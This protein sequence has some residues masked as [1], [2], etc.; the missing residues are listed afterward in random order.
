MIHQRTHIRN[1]AFAA[2]RLA[3]AADITMKRAAPYD[4]GADLMPCV[5]VTGGDGSAGV[6]S[7]SLDRVMV[8]EISIAARGKPDAIEDLLDDLQA[9]VEVAL[10]A[11][12]S[13]SGT[14]QTSN[15][16]QD[17]RAFDKAEEV[18]GEALLK[19]RVHYGTT[20][21]DPTTLT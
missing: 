15:I 4:V 8:L 17:V 3:L 2:I 18:L 10:A 20:R 16:T 7:Q 13:L 1:A 11:D 19:Y 9:Q 21:R 14:C 6:S 5:F 12:P